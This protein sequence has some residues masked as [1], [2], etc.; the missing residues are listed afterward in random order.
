MLG[1]NPVA[2]YALNPGTDGTSAAPDLTGN[3]NDGNASGIAVAIGPTLYI[4]NAA[5]F[6]GAAS[7]DLSQGSD[8]GLL[9]FSGPITLEAW[10]Q[11]T[12]STQGP[13][14]II[15][16]G[17]DASQ[18]DDEDTLRANVG[19]YYGGTYSDARGNQG[20]TGGLQ[21]TNWTYVVCTYDGANWN[22]YV[23]A[24][25]VQSSPDTVGALDFS[26]DWMIGDGSA[27]GKPQ[28]TLLG[29]ISQVHFT[30]DGLTIRTQ[31]LNHFYYGE[32]NASPDVSPPIIT[33]QPQPQSTYV[34]GS[35][36]FSVG[37]VSAFATTNQWFKNGQSHR[38]PDQFDPHAQ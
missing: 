12:N 17:Y 34:G 37:V 31:V 30:A 27:S 13:A 7:I 14:D 20:V 21:T 11:P 6:D 25:L 18:N 16:K 36:T 8:S 35:V 32:I 29:N 19:D 1:D 3:D 2:H 24:T 5:N 9:N 33:A 4:T 15:A 10:V 22:M 26:D 23:N 28:G 38:R